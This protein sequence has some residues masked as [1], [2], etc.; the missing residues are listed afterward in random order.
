MKNYL[1]RRKKNLEKFKSNRKKWLIEK[2]Y[3]TATEKLVQV[4]VVHGS[5]VCREEVPR[6]T[7]IGDDVS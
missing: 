5:G 4:D 2:G 3:V 1:N 6:Y 7:L